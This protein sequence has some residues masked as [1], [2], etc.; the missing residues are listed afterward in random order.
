L[1][2]FS[3]HVA[4]SPYSI[5]ASGA[6][7]SDYAIGYVAGTLTVA[8]V[9]LTIAANDKTMTYGGTLPALTASYSGFVNGDTPA[10]LTT[11]PSLSTVP[12]SSH[13]G[14][15]AITAS[16]AVDP[17]YAI[18]YAA[19]ALAITPA[20]LVVTADSKSK[21][22]G[23][24]NPALTASYGGFVNGDTAAALSGSPALDT[25]AGQYSAPG[26]YPIT[27]AS[28]TLADPDYAFRFVNG[29]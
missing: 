11:P 21:V 6:V 17:D 18:T 25:T 20:T 3:S 4:G 26:A 27:V 14:S 28:G 1:V 23:Q 16:G 29:T 8:P 22:Y 5:T 9:A 15:Y 19:G 2:S 10:S 24:A 7:D 12:A 13:A